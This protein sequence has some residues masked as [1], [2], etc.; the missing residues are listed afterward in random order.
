[1]SSPYFWAYFKPSYVSFSGIW[2]VMKFIESQYE[3]LN[4]IIQRTRFESNHSRCTSRSDENICSSR[5]GAQEKGKTGWNPVYYENWP[6]F[7]VSSPVECQ[8]TFLQVFLKSLALCMTKVKSGAVFSLL[9][10]KST[11]LREDVFD[12]VSRWV[13][14]VQHYGHQ[15]EDYEN[16][17]CGIQ[18]LTASLFSPTHLH[19]IW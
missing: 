12:P 3:M 16:I 13:R 17:S 10:N 4:L 11:V 14:K 5:E 6:F 19:W 9:Y 18:S 7:L 2:K 1:M 15:L 8:C